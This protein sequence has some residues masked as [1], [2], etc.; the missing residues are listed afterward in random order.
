MTWP[1]LRKVSVIE[2][3]LTKILDNSP[4]SEAQRLAT[5]VAGIELLAVLQSATVVHVNGVSALG[6][7]L[8]VGLVKMY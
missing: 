6:L 2:H 3:N 4:N 7:A 8:A 1:W 5:V